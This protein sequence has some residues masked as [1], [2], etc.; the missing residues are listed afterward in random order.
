[1]LNPVEDIVYT[2]SVTG[3]G[4][5]IRTDKVKIFALKIIDP[6]NTFTPNG[7][8]I[9]DLWEIKNLNLYNDCILEIYTPQGLRVYRAANYSKPWDGT[10]NGK[11]L[12]AGTYYYVINT[13]SERKLIAGYVT[14]LK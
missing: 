6:P 2:L 11:P 10:Y 5:C 13:N 12:P 9:N 3:I 7:D 4:G 1:V 14:I 8:G